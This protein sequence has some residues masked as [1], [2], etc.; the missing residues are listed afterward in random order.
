[1][2]E[3]NL[4]IEKHK[5]T[6]KSQYDR[7]ANPIEINKDDL[8]LLK[9]DAGHKLESLYKGPYLVKEVC[10]PNCILEDDEHKQQLIHKDRLKKLNPIYNFRFLNVR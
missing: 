10:E 7:K 1:M 9:N 5:T 4:F 8:V 3:L 6:Q 2:Q